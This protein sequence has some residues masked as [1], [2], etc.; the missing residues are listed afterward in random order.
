MLNLQPRL[1]E[2][3]I[4][5]HFSPVSVTLQQNLAHVILFESEIYR[6]TPLIE[7]RRGIKIFE[8]K[9]MYLWL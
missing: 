4:T 7:L 5:Y 8:E 2:F 6:Y 9:S 3:L 1:D